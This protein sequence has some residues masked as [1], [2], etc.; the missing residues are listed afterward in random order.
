MES[1]RVLFS[2]LTCYFLLFFL[3][4]ILKIWHFSRCRDRVFGSFVFS[5]TDRMY[6]HNVE[7][8]IISYLDKSKTCTRSH[9]DY[10]IY[11]CIHVCKS[12]R[13]K[14]MID[15]PTIWTCLG[16]VFF[17]MQPLQICFGR[18]LNWIPN[19]WKQKT[20]RFQVH[21]VLD[22]IK[23]IQIVCYAWLIPSMCG[24]YLPTFGWLF[25]GRC[26]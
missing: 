7:V 24:I 3:Q 6:V 4:M 25:N 20:N 11:V 16:W 8:Y 17:W 13:S 9:C 2:W 19:P 1:K 14:P 12:P 15:Y 5:Y 26:R 23:I 22:E 21:I 10:I 18:V